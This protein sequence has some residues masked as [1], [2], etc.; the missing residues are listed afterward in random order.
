MKYW[1]IMKFGSSAYKRTVQRYIDSDWG[2]LWTYVTD[3]EGFPIV[4]KTYA[5]AED[6]A[7]NIKQPKI[8]EYIV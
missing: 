1:A 4:F 3:D 6:C 8:V 2:P 7:S 5:E